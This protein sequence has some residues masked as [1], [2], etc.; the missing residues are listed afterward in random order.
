MMYKAGM[1]AVV[2]V[3]GKIVREM[4]SGGTSTVFLP[5][6]SEYS[7]KFKNNDSRRAAV[8]ITIDDKDVLKGRQLVV[9]ANSESEVKGFLEDDGSF[10]KNAFRFI[11]KTAQIS[12]HRGDK[13]N[14]GIIRIE[15]Q[16]EE[17]RPVY[18]Y[19][20]Q[21]ILREK[22]FKGH[23]NEKSVMRGGPS[24]S[25][26]SASAA[27]DSLS[28]LGEE[29]S[30]GFFATTKS[31]NHVGPASLPCAAAPVNESGITVAGS[32]VN[33]KFGTAYVGRLDPTKHVIVFELKGATSSGEALVAPILT[34]TKLE[35]PTCGK[36][37][38]SSAKFCSG[39][40][41]CLV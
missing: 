24:G 38:K 2:A 1:V 14:D 29:R 22:F 17:P 26:F 30:S 18:Q 15:F 41:T 6:G 28:H 34:R 11:E 10:A 3:A 21:P 35:C 9:D 19:P 5:F 40:S 7:I 25:S 27:S 37:S 33:Q 4:N 20:S 13:I 32:H 8:T 16:Y 23:D 12:E 39:C 36:K 31:L